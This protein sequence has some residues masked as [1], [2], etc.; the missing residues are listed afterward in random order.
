VR[1]SRWSSFF[2]LINK[3]RIT[4]NYS[5]IQH[6]F[7]GGTVIEQS[8]NQPQT[9]VFVDDFVRVWDDD[10]SPPVFVKLSDLF[11]LGLYRCLY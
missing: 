1:S 9:T 10:C 2:C 3:G 8:F 11:W 6:R 5:I 4:N 7:N